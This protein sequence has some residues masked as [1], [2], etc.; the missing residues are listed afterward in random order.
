MTPQEIIIEPL[1][2]EQSMEQMED[3]KYTFKVDRRANKSEIKKAVEKLFG[4][5]VKKVNTIQMPG[6]KR[7]LGMH[8]G[9]T[10][11]WKK[12]IVSLTEDSAPIEFFEGL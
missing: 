4:V 8:V 12:A 11:S 10:S 9:R 1:I 6:K 3:K 5:K 2:T 7:R